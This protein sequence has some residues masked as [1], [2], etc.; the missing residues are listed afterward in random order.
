M[1]DA[2]TD[3]TRA[4][5]SRSSKVLSPRRGQLPGGVRRRRRRYGRKAL[6][7]K[8]CEKSFYEQ[9]GS[10]SAAGGDPAG[11]CSICGQGSPRP[12]ETAIVVIARRA[13]VQSE[14]APGL[15]LAPL[16]GASPRRR[17][18]RMALPVGRVVGHC[19]IRQC[20]RAKPQVMK[21]LRPQA[22]RR[23]A[24][25]GPSPAARYECLP[26]YGG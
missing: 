5:V 13:P 11:R 8:R 17:A 19:W 24:L 6:A 26:T 2:A 14:A 18:A 22:T 20:Q 7:G 9:A 15:A 3:S 25:P 4:R 10:G 21:T 12:N 23:F 16:T 1:R